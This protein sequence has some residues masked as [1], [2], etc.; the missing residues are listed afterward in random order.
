MRKKF[1]PIRMEDLTWGINVRDY[2]SEIENKQAVSITN[3]NFEWNKL[4]TE[5][6]IEQSTNPSAV[7]VGALSVDSNDIWTVAGWDVL[8]NGVAQWTKKGIIIK[9]NISDFVPW[10]EYIIT[11][12]SVQYRFVWDTILEFINNIDNQL[13]AAGF[14]TD[15]Q[16]DSIF[17]LSNSNITYSVTSNQTYLLY[18]RDDVT[19][20]TLWD[21]ITVEVTVDWVDYRYDYSYVDGALNAWQIDIE[22][23]TGLKD[24][25]PSQYSATIV[26]L[27]AAL[28]IVEDY[29]SFAWI[30]INNALSVSEKKKFE[31]TYKYRGY[32][33]STWGFEYIR[34]DD[35]DDVLFELDWNEVKWPYWYS[36]DN[37]LAWNL[38]SWDTITINWITITVPDWTDAQFA[39]DALETAM[40]STWLITA[41]ASNRTAFR[42]EVWFFFKDWSIINS[43]SWTWA[44]AWVASLF[45]PWVYQRQTVSSWNIQLGTYNL[46]DPS[47]DFIVFNTTSIRDYIPDFLVNQINSITWYNAVEEIFEGSLWIKINRDDFGFI[48]I[49]E[50]VAN[51]SDME[52]ASWQ[53]ITDISANLFTTFTTVWA[54]IDV[55]TNTQTNA[56]LIDLQGSTNLVR[57]N[58]TIGNNWGVLFVD[59]D[60]WGASY[61]YDDAISSIWEDSVWLPTVWTIYNGKI[62]LWGYDWNDNII[63]SKTSSP[64]QPLNILNFSDYSSWGQSVSGW[65]KWLITGMMVWENWLYVFKNNSVWYTNSERD[66]PDSLSFNFIF[67]KITSNWALNQNVITEVDQ[68]IFYLDW[69]NRAVRRLGYEQNLTTLRD[70]SVSREIAKLFDTLPAEQSL[71][72]SHFS[73]PYYQLSLTDWSSE[74]ITYSNW[75]EYHLNNK[76]FIYNVENKSW[77]TRTWLDETI[78]SHKWYIALNDWFIYKDFTW[79][80]TEEGRFFS[81]KYTFW[82]DISYKKFGG[83]DIIGRVE[84]WDVCWTQKWNAKK[85]TCNIYIQWELIEERT[86]TFTRNWNFQERIDLY[87]QW[88]SFEFELIHSWEWKIEIF[89]VQPHVVATNIQE[90]FF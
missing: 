19:A 35:G 30:L 40:N 52:N 74:T 80:T 60:Q 82:D 14:T 64:T 17:I 9:T 44:F 21:V 68:E 66:S 47:D 37:W 7:W 18:N 79:N 88:R 6:W 27:D 2:A 38:W 49:N 36:I 15:K 51:P 76:H 77:T 16:W 25:L 78:V 71:A 46:Y 70:V 86:F 42:R 24:E 84:I 32:N 4:I 10:I 8:K 55:R 63:F 59:K 72:T 1:K 56:D 65:D 67:N 22:I 23:M 45:T 61:L 87:D 34:L 48:E 75:N 90:N 69:E 62:V 85:L 11:I 43:I 89:D 39:A 33:A 26:N 31:Y 13:S 53:E 5:K 28:G 57:G 12:D 20:Y 29:D 83:F 50:D 54:F 41:V 73:Y 81:K 3:W 58:L